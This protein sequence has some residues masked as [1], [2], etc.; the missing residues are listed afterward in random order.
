MKH[1]D[2]Q[3]QRFAPR[4]R[5]DLGISSEASNQLASA[6]A[7]E[8]AS[9]PA[10]ARLE[11]RASTPV[12]LGQRLDELVSFQ[13]FMQQVHGS[14]ASPPLVRAQVVVQN[15]VCFVYLGESCFKVLGK[16]LPST[17]AGRACCRF[18]TDNP[19]RAFRNALAHGNWRYAP[20]FGGLTYWARKGSDQ[21]EPLSQFEVTQH[22]LD[23]W[24]ALARCTGYAAFTTLGS[25]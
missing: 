23:F 6:I 1:L 11:A 15:Y 17:S 20:G 12:D 24:Q 21:A 10:S 18:L 5:D 13:A 4:L 7:A 3:M 8:V 19:V 22:E 25:S 14:P 2:V 9:L 16:L